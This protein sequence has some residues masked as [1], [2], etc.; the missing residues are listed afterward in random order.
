LPKQART[1]KAVYRGLSLIGMV[2]ILTHF[3]GLQKVGLVPS[4]ALSPD[5]SNIPGEGIK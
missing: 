5:T 3:G 4:S 1:T 2:K